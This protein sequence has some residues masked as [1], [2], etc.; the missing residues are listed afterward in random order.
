MNKYDFK[1]DEVPNQYIKSMIK[2]GIWNNNAPVKIEDLRLIT[3]IHLGFDQKRHQGKLI[4]HKIID[5]NIIAI[6]E[7]LLAKNFYI[8]KVNLIDKYQGNDHKSMI[9]NNSSAFNYRYINNSNKLSI[10]SFGLAIDINPVQNPCII[11]DEDNNVSVLPKKG[12][13]YLNRSKQKPGMIEPVVNIFSKYGFSQWGGNWQNPIDY[14][15]FQL[16]R[17]KIK[18]I[19]YQSNNL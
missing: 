13:N 11:I 17:E 5:Q 8:N 19:P 7:E 12:V 3:V 9:D 14:H 16:P 2:H 18:T 4:C 6:F 15:H 10:H 1:S